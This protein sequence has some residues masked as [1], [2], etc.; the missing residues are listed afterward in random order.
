[1]ANRNLQPPPVDKEFFENVQ[2]SDGKQKIR[3]DW[4]QWFDRLHHSLSPRRFQII[5][6]ADTINVNAGYVSLRR[7][8]ADYAVT[9]PAPTTP[10]VELTIEMTVRVAGQITIA[11]TNV[12][13]Q[14][15][16][17]TAIFNAVGDTLILRSNSN[18]WIVY[19]EINMSFS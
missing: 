8:T 19:K 15:S 12:V 16:G 18:K 17:T 1:M 7:T 5:K 4:A 10:G 11:L 9:L 3:Q 14:S 2:T 6:A 13:G